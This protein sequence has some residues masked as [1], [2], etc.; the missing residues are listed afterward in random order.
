MNGQGKMFFF[1]MILFSLYTYGWAGFLAKVLLQ[2]FNFQVGASCEGVTW[3]TVQVM[4]CA[5]WELF[6]QRTWD[7]EVSPVD[8]GV[9]HRHKK[10]SLRCREGEGKIWT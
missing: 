2:F 5:R 3:Q 9:K 8:V 6:E 4:P 10:T 7:L 1:W